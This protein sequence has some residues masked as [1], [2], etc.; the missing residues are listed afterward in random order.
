LQSGK[1]VPGASLQFEKIARLYDLAGRIE[2]ARDA[3]MTAHSEGGP[4]ST[5]VS[6]FLLSFKMN[7]AS[8][9][10]VNLEGIA[11]KGESAEPLLRALFQIR[12]GDRAAAQN[13]PSA[14]QEALIGL[15]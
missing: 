5:L 12:G 14:A 15:A 10:A 2:E 11:E 1:G 7:D 3:Y 9:M 6:A 8:G 13:P 4:D